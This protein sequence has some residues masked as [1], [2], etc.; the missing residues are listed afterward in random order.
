MKKAEFEKKVLE[1]EER[2]ATLRE[3]YFNDA[4]FVKKLEK[5]NDYVT[6]HYPADEY[7]ERM[8]EAKDEIY[9]ELETCL[10]EETN[11]YMKELGIYDIFYRREQLED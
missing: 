1:A 9:S 11:E 3:K 8:A 6:E 5:A 10:T 2:K 7:D 4:Y